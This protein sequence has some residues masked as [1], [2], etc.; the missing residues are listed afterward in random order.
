MFSLFGLNNPDFNE[1]SFV[2]FTRANIKPLVMTKPYNASIVGMK[3]QLLD[4][5][6][7]INN[8][9]NKE[10]TYLVPAKV[11]T[12]ELTETE[13]LKIAYLANKQIYSFSK[14]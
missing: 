11:G 8:R 7:I 5:F 12:V 3:K 4:K 10:K 13:I 14:R 2:K 6:T 9:P 1:L